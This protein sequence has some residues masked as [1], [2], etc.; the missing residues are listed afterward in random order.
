MLEYMRTVVE[1][2]LG[3][4]KSDLRTSVILLLPCSFFLWRISVKPQA[5][6]TQSNKEIMFRGRMLLATIMQ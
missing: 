6:Q 2:A 1:K 4:G 3:I 5:A